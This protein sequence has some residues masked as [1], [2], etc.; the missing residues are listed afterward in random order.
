MA[1]EARIVG[2]DQQRNAR[3]ARRLRAG[4]IWINSAPVVFPQSSWGGFKASGIGRELGPWGMAGCMGT[5]HVTEAR[6]A[7][8]V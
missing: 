1:E 8:T 6:S 5:K 2:Q 4:H 3:L 7:L